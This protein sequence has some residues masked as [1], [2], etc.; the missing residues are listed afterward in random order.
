M[1]P[2]KRKKEWFDEESLWRETYGHLFPET[3]F[4]SAIETVDK[5]LVLAQPQGSAA[6]DLA[7]GPGRCSIALAKRGFKVT[8]VDCTSYLLDKAQDRAQ[9]DQL[10][11]EWVLMDMRDFVRPNTYDVA[12]SIFTS[13]GFF[14]DPND[15][16][17]V[18]G[19]VFESLR[20]SGAF[21]LDVNGKE[22][23][24]RKYL[25]SSVD[26]LSDGS[27]LIERRKVLDDWTRIQNDWILIKNGLTQTFPFHV[28]VYSGQELRDRLEKVGFVDVKLYGTWEG[29]P[30][31][32]D[33]Q[34][35]IAV[36]K[37]P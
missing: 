21:V 10:Q 19:N 5:A 37:K 34:R 1:K 35:L 16:I 24:A 32:V 17:V 18:L 26:E 29:R 28:N 12:L 3:R 13:F 9:M 6:L 20:S 2:P 25:P 33:A 36:G 14:E 22:V 8:A 27:I 31:N 11:V 7:C 4:A 23:L 15:D 30:Y